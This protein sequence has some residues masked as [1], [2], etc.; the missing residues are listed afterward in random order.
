MLESIIME[1]PQAALPTPTPT[2]EKVPCY[3]CLGETG[4]PFISAQDDLTGKPGIFDFVRCK[5]CGLVFQNPRIPMSQIGEY[6][7][8]EYI[9]HRKKRSWGIFQPLFDRAMDRHDRDKVKLVDKFK[10]L[11]AESEVLDVGCAVGSFLLKVKKQT[12]AR[13]VGVDFKD[14]S[15]FAGF[16]QIE[17][18]HGLFYE[19]ELDE[20]R[21]DLITM[22][23]FLEHDY[24][25]KRSLH[26]AHRILKDDG[27]MI[28]EVPRLDS[29]T[30][31][32][33]RD[34][35]P[36]L[37]APQHTVL[38][39]KE[40]LLKFI[41][42]SGFEVSNYL[43]YGAFPPYFYLFTGFIFKFLKGKGLNMNQWVAPYF[44]GQLLYLP[45]RPFEKWLNLSMQ[46]V[47]CRKR[48]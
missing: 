32:L 34:R 3:S 8:N 26:T 24:D 1:N 37:Q 21:F 9:A 22:W 6:Y 17:F 23:H 29:L 40:H 12:G 16:E 18:H 20:K 31:W 10:N 44:L 11:R 41:E 19:A 46:T 48:K 39:D 5:S 42:A 4:E 43:G 35:W 36:G 2:R 14:L 47:I 33:Y 15:H 7:D 28:I 27:V 38:F 45:V 13:I 25:P 30:F